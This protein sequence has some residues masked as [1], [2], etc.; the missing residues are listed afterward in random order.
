MIVRAASCFLEDSQGKKYIDLMM[1]SGTHLLGHGFFSDGLQRLIQN[2]TLYSDI[3][4]QEVLLK[5]KL[6]SI[7]GCEK[8]VIFCNSGAEATMRAVRA[9]RAYTGKKKILMFSGSWHGGND[10]LLWEENWKNDRSSEG[11]CVPIKPFSK[12]V[13]DSD[14]TIVPYNDFSVFDFIEFIIPELAGVIIEPIQGSNPRE[15][16]GD[17]LRCLREVVAGVPLIFDELI[18]GF[19]MGLKG[20]QGLYNIDA[21]IITYGKILGGGVP[22]GALVG[23][24][25]LLDNPSVVFGGT[26]SGNPISCGM[27][28]L[29]LDH[30]VSNQSL[31]NEL[32]KD[33][34]LVYSE[35]EQIL[36]SFPVQ[37]MK[38]HSMFRFVFTE[39]K[40]NE[41][42]DRKDWEDWNS[43]VKFREELKKQ[44]LLVKSNGICFLCADHME[45]KDRILHK[46]ESCIRKIYE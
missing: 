30:L 26:F 22:I 4:D 16:V 8:S 46:I 21:D 41:M 38:S 13:L 19:R 25:E 17:F 35:I 28:N 40:I 5:S 6:Q 37:L 36:R 31:Y 33:C 20:V 44:G 27:G 43:F 2:G 34:S 10:S 1:G 18:S 24:A 39:R 14:V 11:I 42:R 45:Y 15:D 23:R 7:F 29:V 9:A 12:G 3:S 32:Y